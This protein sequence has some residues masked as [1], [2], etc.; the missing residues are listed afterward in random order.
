MCY[1]EIIMFYTTF[2]VICKYFKRLFF[3]EVLGLQQNREDIFHILLVSTNAYPSPLS[4]H[5]PQWFIFFFNQRW[6]YIDIY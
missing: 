3:R 2:R 5:P 6:T 1:N 4:K